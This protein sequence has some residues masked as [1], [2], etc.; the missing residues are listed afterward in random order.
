LTAL[1]NID[2]ANPDWTYVAAR[3]V[4]NRLYREA[5]K[6]RGYEGKPYGSFYELIQ[7]LTQ[8][9]EGQVRYT[10]YSPE[11]F[12]QYTKEEI[13]ELEKVIDPEKDKLFSCIGIIMLE[14]RY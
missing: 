12:S 1:E 14:S 8:K 7:L 5:Q 10:T 6:N 4:L 3:E 9:Q 13:D 11:L 2:E